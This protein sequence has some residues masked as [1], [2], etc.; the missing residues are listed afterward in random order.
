MLVV[1][2]VMLW[3]EKFSKINLGYY[4]LYYFE[5]NEYNCTITFFTSISKPIFAF[6]LPHHLP[7]FSSPFLTI[8]QSML[9]IDYFKKLIPLHLKIL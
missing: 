6:T 8:G 2:F 9:V 3:T 7:Y 5:I 4:T 1:L